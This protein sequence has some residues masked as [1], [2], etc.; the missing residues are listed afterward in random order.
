MEFKMDL[1][2]EHNYQTYEGRDFS[3]IRKQQKEIQQ[4]LIIE[5]G[6]R[7]RNLN[8]KYR[9]NDYYKDLTNHRKVAV[10]DFILSHKPKQRVF[11]PAK[12]SKFKYDFQ[13][14]GDTKRL[15]EIEEKE[16]NAMEEERVSLRIAKEKFKK[17]MIE[18]KEAMRIQKMKE[19]QKRINLRREMMK[20]G[21]DV[22]MM[23]EEKDEGS[24]NEQEIDE[25]KEWQKIENEIKS[26]IKYLTND[27][28]KE[29]DKITRNAFDQW[30][31][32]DFNQFIKGSVDFGKDSIEEIAE[33]MDNKSLSEVEEYHAVFWKKYKKLPNWKKI[34]QRIEEAED[35]RQQNE[36]YTALLKKKMA[37]YKENALTKLK[38]VYRF[39]GEPSVL[40]NNGYTELFDRFVL[41]KVNEYGLN[42]WDQVKRETLQCKL[43]WNNLLL[44]SKTETE[45]KKRTLKLLHLLNMAHTTKRAKGASN[46]D[47]KSSP[48]NK[49]KISPKRTKKIKKSPL[50]NP[51]RK[52]LTKAYMG[53]L[54]EALK[55][56][57]EIEI[58]DEFTKY[59]T[60]C[61]I[62][63][64]CEKDKFMLF[65]MADEGE[66][67][68]NFK[69]LK[70]RVYEDINASTSK[71]T[72]KKR[73]TMH[74]GVETMASPPT[75]RRKV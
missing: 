5:H 70:F 65:D 45:I 52:N 60:K 37:Y 35:K 41:I 6:P 38:L 32:R 46:N 16:F 25:K 13:I 24:G 15:H 43:F 68:Q 47:K 54:V 22:S 64:H 51:K 23:M 12:H 8:V 63:K 1:N 11:S 2:G 30:S 44:R 71:S 69:N 50:S 53:K 58:F 18:K 27:E 74:D 48:K 49:K 55:P 19:S 59:W 33:N 36:K 75:K 4:A 31:L 72:G 73:K 7:Q 28:E 57:V 26:K 17:D 29:R 40:L 62:V 21:G 20:N 61:R 10:S 3:N 56:G 42:A 9:E 14:F 34:I 39:E 66:F 67:E